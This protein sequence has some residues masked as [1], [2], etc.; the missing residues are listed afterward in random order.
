MTEP[1]KPSESEQP[2]N[3]EQSKDWIAET[4]ASIA[5]RLDGA[6][7]SQT[8]TRVTLAAMAIVSA[9]MLI[10]SYN[11]YFSYDYR[12]LNENL[13]RQLKQDNVPDVLMNQAARDWAASR[14]IQ[15]SLLGIR[16]SV[17]DAPVLGTAVLTVLSLWLV[18]ATRRENHTIGFLLWD[19]DTPKVHY[20]TGERW[21]GEGLNIHGERWLIFQAL[22]ANA[23]FETPD[24]S[25]VSIN[26]LEG[27]N[28]LLPM[29]GV[30]GFLEKHGFGFIR[31]FF[32]TFPIIAALVVFAADRYSYFISDPFNHDGEP[33]G[34]DDPFFW[35]S[36]VAYFICLIPL[37]LCCQKSRDFSSATEA[38]LR[39]YCDKLFRDMS[40]LS[41]FQRVGNA[42]ASS[43]QTLQGETAIL[44]PASSEDCAENR[45]RE[46]EGNFHKECGL[47]RPT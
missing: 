41:S 45:P 21:P 23:L 25:L 27:K 12:Y 39:E 17:D 4:A 13:N 20:E 19:T 5:A 26:S 36:M 11:A 2:Q 33:P 46:E 43:L 34:I 47:N 15:I 32:F 37:A 10:A 35:P 42:G 6:K 1:S 44:L 9:M 14:T 30:R 29:D 18:L 31:N 28:P 40:S 3:G 16:V 8:Q 38:V 22:A 7:A 24:M